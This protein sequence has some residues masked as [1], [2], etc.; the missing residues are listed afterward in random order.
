VTFTRSFVCK[1]ILFDLDGV[2]VNSAECV[3]RTWRNWAARHCID[4]EKVIAYAHGRRT[5]ETVQLVAPELSVDAELAT[6]EHSEAMTSE[7]VYEIPG[8]RELLEMLPADRWAVVTSGVRAVAEFRVRYTRLP[9]PSIMICAEEISRGKP[10]PEGYLTA[11]ARLGRSTE[12]CIV[13]E[14]APAGIEAAHN[15]G[16]RAIAI[17]STYPAHYLG[18][19]AAV[20]EQLSDL[21]MVYDGEQI[22]INIDSRQAGIPT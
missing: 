16:M 2:L 20:V 3:E 15:A 19:A 9:T 12:D 4:P 13:I 17:A 8:A 18:E 22:L 6:L 7:G 21:T 10:D 11:A 14:D 5:I 1:A